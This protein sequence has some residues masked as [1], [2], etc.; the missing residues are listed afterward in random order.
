MN[1]LFLLCA[2]CT[3][4]S[5]LSLCCF[6]RVCSLS[7]YTKGMF[8]AMVCSQARNRRWLYALCGGNASQANITV[9]SGGL[10][11]S[12]MTPDDRILEVNAGISL[13]AKL[14]VI[15]RREPGLSQPETDTSA[16]LCRRLTPQNVW[17]HSLII[18][19]QNI[20]QLWDFKHVTGFIEMTSYH[21]QSKR[22]ATYLAGKELFVP[23]RWQQRMAL[24][25]ITNG[26]LLKAI[27]V[28]EEWKVCLSKEEVHL[29]NKWLEWY[30]HQEIELTSDHMISTSL[31][32]A[33]MQR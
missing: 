31:L 12:Q 7:C 29:L 27:W 8:K 1:V 21:S 16:A 15:S 10:A 3:V 32:L 4:S 13:H 23:L 33:Y 14:Q 18:F 2:V 25:T 6:Q 17:F 9:V 20:F 11:Q 30:L 28:I 26:L 19:G 24:N 22:F 5:P